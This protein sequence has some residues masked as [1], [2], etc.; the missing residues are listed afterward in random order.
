MDLKKLLD[1]NYDHALNL[2]K[3]FHE[4]PELS[5]KEFDTTKKIREELEAVGIEV[6]D[7]GLKTGVVGKL[8]CGDGKKGLSYTRK[9]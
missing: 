6:L 2:R 1:K 3:F 9:Y 8:V 5:S 4:N 7:L